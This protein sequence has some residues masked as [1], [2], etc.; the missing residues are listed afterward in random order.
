MKLQFTVTVVVDLKAV[1]DSMVPPTQSVN[2]AIDRALQ[3]VARGITAVPGVLTTKAS[4]DHSV[5]TK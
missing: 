1:A 5:E 4:L 2:A 3:N